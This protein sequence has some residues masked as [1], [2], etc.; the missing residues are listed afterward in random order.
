MPT[1]STTTRPPSSPAVNHPV[2]DNGRDRLAD[3][4]TALA[5]IAREDVQLAGLTRVTAHF[6]D[7]GSI[8]VVVL[9][10]GALNGSLSWSLQR[11]D[12]AAHAGS[13]RHVD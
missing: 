8:G 10:G 3:L 12:L 7:D 1:P 13:K 9:R 4:A 2:A 5:I 11:D 6:A